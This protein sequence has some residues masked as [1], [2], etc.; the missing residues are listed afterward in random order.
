MVCQD[1]SSPSAV[2][3]LDFSVYDNSSTILSILSSYF[4]SLPNASL[5]SGMTLS[6]VRRLQVAP[7]TIQ[8]PDRCQAHIL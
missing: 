8:S 4:W 6:S 2:P 7:C 5:T 3:Q 1:S